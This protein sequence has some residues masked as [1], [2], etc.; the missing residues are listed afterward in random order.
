MS[1]GIL[2]NISTEFVSSNKFDPMILYLLFGHHFRLQLNINLADDSDIL[3][4]NNFPINSR[5]INVRSTLYGVYT[6][7]AY[8]K[9]PQPNTQI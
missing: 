7:K 8:N 3:I 1:L 9:Y 6:F 4:S 5:T 2:S